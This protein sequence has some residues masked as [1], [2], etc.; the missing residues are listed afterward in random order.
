MWG[1]PWSEQDERGKN[2]RG[3]YK[4]EVRKKA[5]HVEWEMQL[6]GRVFGMY[7]ALD[8]IFFK[9]MERK[10]KSCS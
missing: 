4:Q 10:E 3:K 9:K 7:P 5:N 1:G 8:L 6:G 2:R